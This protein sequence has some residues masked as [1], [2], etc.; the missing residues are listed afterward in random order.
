MAMV[1]II[2][3]RLISLSLIIDQYPPCHLCHLYWLWLF[4]PTIQ[5]STSNQCFTETQPQ[6]QLE[7]PQKQKGKFRQ[8]S[9]KLNQLKTDSMREGLYL[10]SVQLIVEAKCVNIWMSDVKYFLFLNFLSVKIVLI[11]TDVELI[12][13]CRNLFRKFYTIFFH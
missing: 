9:E 12:Q 6:P 4:L 11:L 10:P 13:K 8:T 3:K 5:L 7:Y 2:N 1:T